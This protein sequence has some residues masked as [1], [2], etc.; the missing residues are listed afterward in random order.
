MARPTSLTPD[1]HARIVNA[2]RAGAFWREAAAFAGVSHH[3]LYNW[4]ERGKA[5]LERR[6]AGA[7]P[8]MHED[9]FA[10][11]FDALTRAESEA[12]IEAVAHWKRAAA[13]DWRAAKEWLARRHHREWGEKSQLALTGAEGGAV[14]VNIQTIEALL[15]DPAVAE[16]AADASVDA[17]LARM[18]GKAS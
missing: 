4:V 11:F 10:E 9:V 15:K 5:E 12:I 13:V 6:E 17:E 7:E 18:N 8:D 2:V 1:V 3:S 14:E 16:A